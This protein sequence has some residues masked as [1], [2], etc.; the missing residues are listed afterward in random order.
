[1]PRQLLS[2]IL[3]PIC[4]LVMRLILLAYVT[5]RFYNRAN[6]IIFSQLMINISNHQKLLRKSIL[7]IV[8][9]FLSDYLLITFNIT[10]S[11]PIYL[12]CC[13][14]KSYHVLSEMLLMDWHGHTFNFI[15]FLKLNLYLRLLTYQHVWVER[16][17]H[18]KANIKGSIHLFNLI[19][20]AVQ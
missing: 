7:I 14:L 4:L 12:L 13:K 15:V 18:K 5:Q 10:N 19:Q 6:C 16:G 20:T 8:L 3:M 11:G 1:M 2:F 9:K 17:T